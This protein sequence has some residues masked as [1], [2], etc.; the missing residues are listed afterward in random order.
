[1]FSANSAEL[2]TESKGESNTDNSCDGKH[3]SRF[4]VTSVIY[5][6]QWESLWGQRYLAK[7]KDTQC[8]ES[9]QKGEA[10]RDVLVK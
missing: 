10:N 4:L 8:G 9:E 3:D 5:S 6:F 2:K 1:M 7:R